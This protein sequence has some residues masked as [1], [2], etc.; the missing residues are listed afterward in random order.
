[1]R[2]KFAKRVEREVKRMTGV[3]VTHV[4]RAVAPYTN[5]RV[6]Y[7]IDLDIAERGE[8]RV[9]G[10]DQLAAWKNTRAIIDIVVNND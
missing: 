5:G 2:R 3:K 1:M 9:Y 7:A 8:H 10:R 4:G 6:E